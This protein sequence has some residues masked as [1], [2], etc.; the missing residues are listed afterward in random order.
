MIDEPKCSQIMFDLIPEFETRWAT[1]LKTWGEDCG[2]LCVRCSEFAGLAIEKFHRMSQTERKLLF[3]TVEL[4]L[5]EGDEDVQDA[6]ATCFLED[7]A[8]A[9]YENK[10][11]A[12]LLV[13]LL[14]EESRAYCKAWDEFTGVKTPGLCDR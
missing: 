13:P 3:G 14:G 12:K 1:Y 4:F 7:I 5:T 10:V 8:S 11:S 9:V 6:V 2:G